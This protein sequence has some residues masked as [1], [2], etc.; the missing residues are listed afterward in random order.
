MQ[1]DEMDG[2]GSSGGVGGVLVEMRGGVGDEL[3]S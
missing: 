1:G 2:G 3:S